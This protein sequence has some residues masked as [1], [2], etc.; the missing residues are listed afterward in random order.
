MVDAEQKKDEVTYFR[1]FQEMAWRYC[2]FLLL[3]RF[4]FLEAPL[5]SV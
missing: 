2:P 3:I 1:R 5:I 4:I